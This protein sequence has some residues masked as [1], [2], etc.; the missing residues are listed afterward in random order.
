[1]AYRNKKSKYGIYK[2]DDLFAPYTEEAQS[3][4]VRGG[5][6][7]VMRFWGSGYPT[8]EAAKAALRGGPG[9]FPGP[10]AEPVD[11]KIG[12]RVPV[13]SGLKGDLP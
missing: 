2:A 7:P 11:P 12:R 5:Y 1:M 6:L 8:W 3:A 13:P 4:G 9:A 10:T